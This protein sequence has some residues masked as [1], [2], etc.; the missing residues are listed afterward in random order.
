MG[1]L[2][3]RRNVFRSG[4]AQDKRAADS[5]AIFVTRLLKGLINKKACKDHCYFLS[6]TNLKSIG[7]ERGSVNESGV[8][9]FP[10]TFLCRTFLPV[11]GEIMHGVM[12]SEWTCICLQYKQESFDSI[13][14]LKFKNPKR[15][16]QRGKVYEN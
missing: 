2:E 3:M 9:F 5:S 11:K 7:R 1:S 10:V 6:V 8:V 4:I 14:Q 15:W 16:N 13:S 12:Y